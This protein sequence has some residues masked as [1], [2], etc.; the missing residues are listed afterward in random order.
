MITC[1]FEDGNAARLRHVTVDCIVV[2]D[3]Q[4]LLGKRAAK[5]LEG[6]KWGLLGGYMERD[7]TCAEAAAREVT[8]ESGWEITDLKLLRIKDYPERPREDRQNISF[9]YVAKAVRQTGR[10]D[11]ETA[12][13]QWF[14]LAELPPKDQV[15]FDHYD[16]ILLYKNYLEQPFSLPALGKAS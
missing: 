7:E 11:W 1:A 3:G 4:V 10:P 14:S 6:G 9:V 2:Q 5:L 13:L 8:E 12:E 15:A 16:D